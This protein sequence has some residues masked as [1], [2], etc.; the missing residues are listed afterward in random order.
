MRRL[1]PICS[2]IHELH[3]AKRI[4]TVDSIIVAFKRH[5]RP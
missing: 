5:F 4:D 1:A 3:F 2:H